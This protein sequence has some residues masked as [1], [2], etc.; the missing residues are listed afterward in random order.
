MVHSMKLEDLPEFARKYKR[1]GYDVRL[2]NGSYSLVKIWSKREP[3][4]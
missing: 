3:G 1:R 4:R 2:G